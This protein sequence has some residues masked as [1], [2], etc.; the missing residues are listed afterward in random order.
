MNLDIRTLPTIESGITSLIKK[1]S[2]VIFCSYSPQNGTR[3]DLI[4][5]NITGVS[6]HVHVDDQGGWLVTWI[7]SY[8]LKAMVVTNNGGLL[9][10]QYVMDKMRASISDAVCLAEI[11]GHCTCEEVDRQA[12]EIITF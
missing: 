9:H 7:N 3:Y 11:I 5:T 8:D 12:E 6:K 4:F 10:W 1:D 2:D